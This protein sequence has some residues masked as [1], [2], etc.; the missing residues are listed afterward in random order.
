[1]SIF[2]HFFVNISRTCQCFDKFMSIFQ[3]MSIFQHIYVNISK[4]CQYF[5]ECMSKA[6]QEW[7]KA[8]R[9]PGSLQQ[10]APST[11]SPGLPGSWLYIDIYGSHKYCNNPIWGHKCGIRNL[12]ITRILGGPGL[13]WI[14]RP[15]ERTRASWA[16]CATPGA[17]WTYIQW[18][19]DM[20]LKYW[21]KF[22][23]ILTFSE[24]LTF[25]YWNIKILFFIDII[26][27]K[28][29]YVFEILT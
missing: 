25:I 13:R 6:L 19:I 3:K 21:H 1:M 28:Y 23:E 22:I 7:R 14:P 10:G 26:L 8:L 4:K 15:V 9:K 27:S 11:S 2:Q 18:N 29:R 12:Y 24:I 16:L 5:I 17:F 20:F